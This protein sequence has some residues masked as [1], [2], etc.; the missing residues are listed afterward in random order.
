MKQI[1]PKGDMAF[2]VG[3]NASGDGSIILHV[4][5]HTEQS[6]II[7]QPQHALDALEGVVRLLMAQERGKP[8]ADIYYE[9]LTDLEKLRE[10]G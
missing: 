9:I 7:C 5:E 1:R 6:Q 4:Y 10:K 3:W 8:R 2:M